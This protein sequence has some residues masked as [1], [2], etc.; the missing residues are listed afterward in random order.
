MAENEQNGWEKI[1]F[2]APAP[3]RSELETAAKKKDRTLSSMIRHI[4]NKFLK[5][6]GTDYESENIKFLY[7][8]M[9]NKFKLNKALTDIEKRKLQ[10]MELEFKLG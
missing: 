9:V 4:V 6:A 3:F 2:K 7:N 8:L 1:S 10:A 5:G